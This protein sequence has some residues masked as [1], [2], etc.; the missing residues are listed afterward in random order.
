MDIMMPRLEQQ[1]SPAPWL[2]RRSRADIP[3]LIRTAV[4]QSPGASVD[5]VV[6]RL[7]RWNVE[8]SGIIVA[9]W[10]AK[11]T[12]SV[13]EVRQDRQE[14]SLVKE[15]NQDLSPQAGEPQWASPILPSQTWIAVGWARF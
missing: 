5:Q 15:R 7:A 8:A 11:W 6:A 13:A 14:R 2:V 1:P 12:E 3:R 9:M 10:L 4:E